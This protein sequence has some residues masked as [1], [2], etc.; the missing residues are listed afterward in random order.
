MFQ[1]EKIRKDFPMLD[2]KTCQGKPL[3]YL[4]NGATTFK[5]YSVIKAVTSYYTDY[6]SNAHRGD[7]ELSLIVDQ[8]FEHCRE[9]VGKFINCD[10]KEVVFTNGASSSLNL[11][12][13]GYGMKF[14]KKGDVIL[15]TEAEHASNILPWFKVASITG[16]TVEYIPLN[17]EGRLTFD[18]FKKAMHENVKLV[19][20]ATVG[21]VLGYIA[22]VKEIIAEAHKYGAVVSIDGAQAVPHIATDVRDLDCDFLSFSSHKM[23]GPTGVGVLYGKYDLLDKMDPF[24]LGGGSN[25]RF[26]A[27]GNLTLKYPPHKFEAGTQPIE[28]VLGLDAAIQY[29]MDLG[30]DNV[31]AHE[32]ELHEYLLSKMKELDNVIIYN[33]TGDTGIVT[34]NV[35]KIFAQDAASYLSTQGVC[36]RSGNHCA[37]ILVDFLKTSA[38][39][40]VSLYIYNTKEDVDKLVEALK[41]T[42]I[43]NCV[44]II[45]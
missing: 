11:V 37:K 25:A 5:P 27:C 18:N 28:A 13:Y 43:E 21:N 24:E 10:P 4:D 32:R 6:T 16:A 19:A 42:T 39:L 36:L 44:D 14:L 9:T 35:K 31:A 33:P 17:E 23:L 41:S 7:Y 29:L 22:P 34:F 38:T 2:G 15:T 12:A 8:K 20:I 30:M 3:V 40:R 26:D 1:T 45:F